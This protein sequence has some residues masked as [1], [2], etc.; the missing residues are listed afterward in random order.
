M[1]PVRDATASVRCSKIPDTTS[2][3][4][5]SCRPEKRPCFDGRPSINRGGDAWSV[6][7]A[8]PGTLAGRRPH[9]GPKTFLRN[10]IR[11]AASCEFV[12]SYHPGGWTG[13]RRPCRIV[14]HQ[15]PWSAGLISCPCSW[16]KL[17]A[18][19]LT[20]PSPAP[21]RHALPLSVPTMFAP[22][23][24]RR[25]LVAGVHRPGAPSRRQ[26][27]RPSSQPS[28]SVSPFEGGAVEPH[29]H[30]VELRAREVSTR[31]AWES[32][33][34]SSP[35]QESWS[36]VPRAPSPSMPLTWLPSFWLMLPVW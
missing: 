26:I 2:S 36:A 18:V 35:R 7:L 12:K 25:G 14:R 22:V 8:A 1:S 10:S 24:C 19:G 5:M 30:T 21:G 20:W 27:S 31:R 28:L 13:N 29:F 17:N 34:R 32:G 6:G 3:S 4:V 16:S 9:E 11:R 33:L 15:S 23:R